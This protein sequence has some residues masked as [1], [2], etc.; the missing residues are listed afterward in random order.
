MILPFPWSPSPARTP[1]CRVNAQDPSG[2]HPAP[3]ATGSRETL[4]ASA[5][6]VAASTTPS[7]ISSAS[8]VAA[9]A[10]APPSKPSPAC[11]VAEAGAAAP[12]IAVGGEDAV[13]TSSPAAAAAA[14]GETESAPGGCEG[15]TGA[16]VAPAAAAP[17]A[18]RPATGTLVSS[19]E[20]GMLSVEDLWISVPQDNGASA[21]T[22]TSDGPDVVVGGPAAGRVGSDGNDGGGSVDASV[23]LEKM[24]SVGSSAALAE[25]IAP[26]FWVVGERSGGDSGG[27]AAVSGGGGG[28][29]DG[30]G[31]GSDED[32]SDEAFEGRHTVRFILAR[33][34]GEGQ[35][36]GLGAYPLS[37]CLSRYAVV[38]TSPKGWS[39]LPFVAWEGVVKARSIAEV[40]MCY[41]GSDT[42]FQM[43]RVYGDV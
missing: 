43:F 16:L 10:A 9:A 21:A 5:F 13:T 36:R 22:S 14:A 34:G 23:K 7:S 40:W 6:P 31:S 41:T 42:R 2:S 24:S 30:V 27:A 4:R 20:G 38:H 17:S 19:G 11:G 37:G 28:G 12:P 39:I 29:G 25:I 18:S 35:G 15:V 3:P 26:R 33:G 1:S 8:T 32:T